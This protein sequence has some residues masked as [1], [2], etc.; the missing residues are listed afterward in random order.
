[1]LSCEE[2]LTDTVVS[3]PEY[4]VQKP[5]FVQKG[6]LS[7]NILSLLSMNAYLTRVYRNSD[8]SL[9][10]VESH[11]TLS[12]DPEGNLTYS[13]TQGASL[14]LAETEESARRVEIC[15]KVSSLLQQLWKET[16]ASGQLSLEEI[17]YNGADTCTLRFGLMADGRFAEREGDWAQVTVRRGAVV[18]VFAALRKM[19]PAE[20][21]LLLPM[22]QAAAALAPGT[23]RLC[24]RLMQEEDSLV[25]RICRVT[26]D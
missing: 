5:D 19:E 24:I 4:A 17:S 21:T 18:G 2:L 16:G 20:Q 26:E 22:Q 12:T 13:S 11:S 10:Y 3:L 23:A 8:G 14:E 9:V 6:E 15:Q 25:P 1:M 7:Q